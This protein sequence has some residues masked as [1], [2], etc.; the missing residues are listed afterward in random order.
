MRARWIALVLPAVAI[1]A[2]AGPRATSSYR[3]K[4][5]YD[6]LY[7]AAV[8]AVPAVGYTIVSSNKADGLIVAQQ[9]VIM[10]SG[11]AVGLN[12]SVANDGGA[13]TMQVNFQSPPLTLALGSFDTNLNDYVGAVRKRVPD[14]EQQP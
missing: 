8:S 13:R 1:A 7:A 4:A 14:L 12:V 2:C 6:R 11:T 3:T 10:G 5:S 9:S